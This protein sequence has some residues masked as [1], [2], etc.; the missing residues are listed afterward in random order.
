[1][2]PQNQETLNKLK[3]KHPSPTNP[4]HIPEQPDKT[5]V[6][7][8]VTE[9]VVVRNINSF[10]NGS[11][12]SIDG[13]LP[14]HLKDLTTPSTG[15][16]G[17]KLISSITNLSNFMLAGKKPNELCSI[18]YEASLCAL[19]KEEGGIRPIAVGNT[20]RRLTAKMASSSVRSDMSSKFAP[21]QV[22]YGTRC[23]CE[24]TA[25]A[26]RTFVKKNRT[27]R[28]VVLKIDFRNAF[29]KLDRDKFLE[30]ML[31]YL[32]ISIPMLRNPFTAFLW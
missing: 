21:R 2:A 16:A 12:T 25:H 8:I 4:L 31:Q 11:S 19:N 6:H 17:L 26:T 29:N 22:G 23:G 1:M 3:L 20:F 7:L 15:E 24:A 30:E 32:P 5:A 13:I 28:A 14:Q 9:K 18:M 27:G 10:P